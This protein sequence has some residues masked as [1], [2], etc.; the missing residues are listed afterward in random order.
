MYS[1][2]NVIFLTRILNSDTTCVRQSITL[3]NPKIRCKFM[4][5]SVAKYLCPLLSLFEI[6]N[7]MNMKINFVVF[8]IMRW[9]S[10]R[11][12]NFSQ[13]GKNPPTCALKKE[14]AIYLS[15]ITVTT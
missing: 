4:S 12:I 8:W 6:R 14:A 15:E 13:E 7:F 11:K 10:L 9:V 2:I 3:I 1:N 5:S